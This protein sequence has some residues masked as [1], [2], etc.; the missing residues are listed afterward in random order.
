MDREN[1]KFVVVPALR[2]MGKAMDR[3]KA[4]N[5]PFTTNEP[6]LKFVNKEKGETIN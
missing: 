3:I 4:L 1:I 6:L 2:S 5:T